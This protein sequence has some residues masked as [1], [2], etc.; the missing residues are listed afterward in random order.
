[1]VSHR[2]VLLAVEQL[3]PAVQVV[4]QHR[5]LEPV[6]VHHPA[7][8]WMRRQTRIV[9]DF[10]DEV[11]SRRALIVEPHQRIQM[12]IHIGHED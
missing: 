8:R 5:D 1:M 12:P 11:L 4:G 6:G 2:D 9:I 7:I 10:L 3:Q